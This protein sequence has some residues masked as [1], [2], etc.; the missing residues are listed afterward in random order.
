MRCLAVTCNAAIDTTYVLDRFAPGEIHRVARVASS[1]GGKGNNVARVLATLGHTVT[2][3]GFAGGHAGRFI[4]EGL[5]RAGVEPDFVAVEG[6]SR[7]CLTLVETATGVVSEI[8]EPGVRVAAADADRLLDRVAALARN[9]GAVVVS[10][11]LAPGLPD[12]FYARLLTAARAA[13]AFVALDT[14]GQALRRG[15]SGR[16]DLI[17]PNRNELAGLLDRAVDTGVDDLITAASADLIGPVLA[18]DALVLL[19]LGPA[20]A[21]LIGHR[22]AFRAEA[23]AVDVVNTVGCGDAL[24]AGFLDARARGA[25]D[26][27]ALADAVAVGTAAALRAEIGAVS[28]AD[29]AR[30]RP[31]VRVREPVAR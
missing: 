24:L 30:L 26:T 8:R 15:I 21:V 25:V 22:G 12:D 23:P 1:P 14:S 27:G 31:G 29:V 4:A 2:A 10:G 28:L 20:G 16:P 5:A 17:A 19:S 3:T 11:S 13:G 6:E 7:V 18:E 9:A